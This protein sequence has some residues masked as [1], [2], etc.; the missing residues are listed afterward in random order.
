MAVLRSTP[1]S[2][3]LVAALLLGAL[4]LVPPLAGFE[5]YVITGGSMSG[6]ID[7][8]A[9]AYAR[10]VPVADLRAGDVITYEPPRGLGPGG[11]VTHRIVWTGRGANGTRAFRT[12]GDANAAADPWRFELPGRVQARVAV[13]VPYA[14]YAI[15][16]L[17]VRWVRMLVI[18]VPA[19]VVAVAVLAGAWRDAEAVA[20]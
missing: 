9:I 2:A 16:A 7:R 3:A 1:G 20:A 14:G 12:K 15:A 13:H 17:G 8:G 4:M 10:P 5:R 19:L 6:T 11:K 18:G